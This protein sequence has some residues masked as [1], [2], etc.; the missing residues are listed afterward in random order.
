[1]DA[2]GGSI[3]ST[4][5]GVAIRH[6]QLESR[7]QQCQREGRHHAARRPEGWCSL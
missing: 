1:M 6:H 5:S 7:H 2:G 3:E 4:G